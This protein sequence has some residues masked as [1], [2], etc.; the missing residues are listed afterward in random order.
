MSLDLDPDADPA[1]TGS[2]V[3]VDEDREGCEFIDGAWVPK[4]PGAPPE[5]DRDG[6]EEIDGVWVEK[7]MGNPAVLVEGNILAAVR[8]HV[9]SRKL[10]YVLGA[11]GGYRMIPARPNLLRKPDVSFVAA[12]RL[13][14][15]EAKKS[16]WKIAPDLAV[17]VV[18]PNDTADGVETKLDEYLQA[19]VRLVWVVY[20]PTRNVWAYRPDGTANR[21]RASDPLPGEEVLPEFSVKVAELFEVL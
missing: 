14:A 10:G 13:S 16:E 18:S 11:N 21:Y 19:G 12:G 17:E 6:L 2:A 5:P 20:V 3:A 9:R 8:D 15:D 4:H 7:A 1:G